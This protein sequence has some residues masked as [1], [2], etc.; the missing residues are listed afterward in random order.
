LFSDDDDDKDDGADAD[1]GAGA[2]AGAGTSTAKAKHSKS[3]KAAKVTT[4]KDPAAKAAAEAAAKFPAFQA[5][6]DIHMQSTILY[7]LQDRITLID[8]NLQCFRICA[9][10]GSGLPRRR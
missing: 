2:G 10:T 5:N 4:N 9:R 1:A 6:L 7:P 8:R 3:K